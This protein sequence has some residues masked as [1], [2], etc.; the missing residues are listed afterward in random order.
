MTLTDLATEEAR[1]QL[2]RDQA[3]R[4]VSY[5]QHV[6]QALAGSPAAYA[7]L[8]EDWAALVAWLLEGQEP[9]TD[10]DEDYGAPDP[11]LYDQTNVGRPAN[12]H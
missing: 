5:Q 1:A 7:Q 4:R 3:G 6:W 9:W 2:W 10:P 12:E 11:V 8:T